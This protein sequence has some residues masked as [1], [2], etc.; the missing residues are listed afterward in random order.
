MQ[1]QG[2]SNGAIAAIVFVPFLLII[3]AIMVVI[4]I[5]LYFTLTY[6]KLRVTLHNSFYNYVLLTGMPRRKLKKGIKKRGF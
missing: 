5:M 4:V 6:D 3:I 2:L 1:D